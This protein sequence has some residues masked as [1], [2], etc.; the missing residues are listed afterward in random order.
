MLGE[1]KPVSLP[2]LALDQ[3]HDLRREHNTA[4]KYRTVLFTCVECGGALHPVR[5]RSGLDIFA[6]DPNHGRMCSMSNGESVRHEFLKTHICRPAARVKG[7]VAEVEVRGDAVDPDTGY[8]PIVDVVAWREDPSENARPYGWE[9]QLSQSTDSAILSRQAVREA[10]L[11]RCSW[12]TTD[13]PAWSR[14][15]PWLR[16][17]VD[18]PRTSVIDGVVRWVDH[19][20]GYGG[21]FMTVEPDL[22]RTVVRSQL[23]ETIRWNDGLGRWLDASSDPS[24]QRKRMPSLI[25]ET[26]HNPTEICNRPPVTQPEELWRPR[27]NLPGLL[28]MSDLELGQLLAPGDQREGSAVDRRTWPAVMVTEVLAAE[29]RMRDGINRRR[30]TEE[31]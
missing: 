17:E 31:D 5:Y 24:K 1:A 20:G 15:V 21:D 4:R 22:L 3:I 16:L 26:V 13:E 27:P 18:G 12:L 19:G 25:V 8:P 6:H 28:P 2:N 10:Y 7:W 30:Q 14:Q 11:E 9:V 23:A 29:A